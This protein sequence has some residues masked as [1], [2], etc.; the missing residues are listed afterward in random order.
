V[1]RGIA[2]PFH[3]PPRLGGRV[4]GQHHAPAA[5][6]SGKDPVPIVQKAGWAPGPVWKGPENLNPARIRSLDRPAEPKFASSNPAEAVGI[7]REKKFSARLP[8]EG[9]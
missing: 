6:P 2:P 3:D 4:G 1:S 9:K 8:S 7:F 5:L